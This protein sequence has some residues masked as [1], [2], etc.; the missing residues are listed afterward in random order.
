MVDLASMS[1][2]R[3]PFFRK[4][5]SI[6]AMVFALLAQEAQAELPS[7]AVPAQVIPVP[8][9]VSAELQ[10][11]ISKT[12]ASTAPKDVPTTNAGWNAQKAEWLLTPEKIEKLSAEYQI[13]VTEQTI[14]GVNCYKIIPVNGPKKNA[15]RLLVYIHGGGYTSGIGI[16]GL[17]EGI[18]LAA[19]SRIP[20]I[21]IDYRM[22]PDFPYPTPTDDA[23]AVW[24]AVTKTHAASRIGLFGS[25]TGGAM[26]LS[27]V[28]KSIEQNLPVP[29]AA[30]AGTPWSDLSE[31]GDSYFTNKYLDPMSYGRLGAAALQYAHGMDLKDP[32]LSPV[33]G[34][35]KG[36]P[37]T[38]LISG[39]RDLFLS[40]TVR[41]DRK[42]RD[43]GSESSLIVYEGQSHGAYI[44]GSELPETRT[45]Y[46]DMAKF[47]E[48]HLAR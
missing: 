18:L 37:P 26:V 13:K 30:I 42:L 7:R 48:R 15:R 12:P 24:K 27:V 34:S 21:A 22:P 9:T 28:Q 8:S 11:R 46:A 14:G 25:S 35:F 10:A 23:M 5:M 39:T 2:A 33:Y 29:G 45:A 20:T 6:A 40:N 32:R 16:S 44:V 43:A 3:A 38:L 17:L 36:F 4:S 19:E 41:V 31:T 47:L 1:R